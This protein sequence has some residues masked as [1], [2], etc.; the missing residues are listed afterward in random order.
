MN[1]KYLF[2]GAV[3]ITVAV[4]ATLIL[5]N[6][7]DDASFENIM[8]DGLSI[9]SGV[10]CTQTL[11]VGEDGNSITSTLYFHKDKMRYDTVI[12][13][14]VQGQKD[15][16]SMSNAEY[17]YVWGKGA[18]GTMFGGENKGLKINND[19]ENNDYSPEYDASELENTDFKVPG[20]E[21]EKWN[22]DSKM[23]ELPEDMEFMTM[24]E[25]MDPANMQM[26]GFG[27]PTGTMPNMGDMCA[28]CDSIP[29]EEAKAECKKGCEI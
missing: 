19:D 18:I 25:A 26:P 22:P 4:V 16:H 29:D 21:C 28:M 23:F 9:N 2:G 17:T 5:K 24:E 10:K 11:D 14:E 12:A 20:L 7:S 13:N 8:M 6:T 15:L 27:E 3:V 1:K